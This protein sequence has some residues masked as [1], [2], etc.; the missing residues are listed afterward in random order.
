[1]CYRGFEAISMPND[2]VRHESAIASACD[3]HPIG[4]EPTVFFQ[5]SINTI[6]HVLIIFAAPFVHN[7]TLK[8]LTI[9]GRAARVCKQ[10]RIA[11]CRVNLKLM[12]PVDAVHSRRS[13]MDTQDQGI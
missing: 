6:H 5:S 8:V 13:T 3:A 4:I 10:D 12:E 2:P 1:Q 9:S 7:T 11:F